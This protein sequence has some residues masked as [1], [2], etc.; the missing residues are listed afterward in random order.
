MI[1]R[2]FG[3][4]SSPNRAG[5]RVGVVEWIACERLGEDANVPEV[6]DVND[7]GLWVVGKFIQLN[8]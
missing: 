6:D 5:Q 2:L 8:V 7:F 3:I 1:R 4:D